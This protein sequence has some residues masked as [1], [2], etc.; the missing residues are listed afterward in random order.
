[1]EDTEKDIILIM[2]DV[3]DNLENEF[4]KDCKIISGESEWISGPYNIF[5]TSFVERVVKA[6]CRQSQKYGKIGWEVSYPE[7]M[8]AWK[9]SKLDFAFGHIKKYYFNNVFEVKRWYG[10][11]IPHNIWADIF[12]LFG[13]IIDDPNI[14]LNRYMII[15]KSFESSE[16]LELFFNENFVE[17]KPLG[18]TEKDRLINFRNILQKEGWSEESINEIFNKYSEKI[19]NKFIQLD[20]EFVIKSKDCKLEVVLLKINI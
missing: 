18:N 14:I 19:K 13:Y 7:F 2:K 6:L 5:E 16:D 10:A 9:N 4:K 1:M 17:M 20:K 3:I 8:P 11:K 12:K 15:I